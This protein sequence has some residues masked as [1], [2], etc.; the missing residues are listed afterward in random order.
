MKDSPQSA[1]GGAG[2]PAPVHRT[3]RT[4]A[5]AGVPQQVGAVVGE[6]EEDA[7]VLELLEQRRRGSGSASSP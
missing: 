6:E 4:A 3:A 7:Q 2:R 5:D 1:A